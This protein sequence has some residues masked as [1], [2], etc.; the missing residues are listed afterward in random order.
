M[1]SERHVINEKLKKT[2]AGLHFGC[3]SKEKDVLGAICYGAC[4]ADLNCAVK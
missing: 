1:S 2:L 3:M 4:P